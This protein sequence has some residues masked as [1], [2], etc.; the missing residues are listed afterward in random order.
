MPGMTMARAPPRRRRDANRAS[1]SAAG[2]Q[3]TM[4]P[5]STANAPF[6]IG[7]A[8]GTMVITRPVTRRSTS[9]R[10]PAS[11][12]ACVVIVPPYV[13][14]VGAELGGLA[15][16]ATHFGD[17][18]IGLLER[19]QVRGHRLCG[20]VRIAVGDCRHHLVVLPGEEPANLRPQDRFAQG[21]P[22]DLL[23]QA[24]QGLEDRLQDRVAAGAGDLAMERLVPDLVFGEVA[25]LGAPIGGMGY[26]AYP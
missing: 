12:W 16:A 1:M 17:R 15:A 13:L 19:P 18:C 2:P 5:P 10:C 8:P 14:G 25:R 4:S 22:Y 11:S 7:M 21:S 24:V 26:G 6:S 9:R 20:P 23:A 3:A